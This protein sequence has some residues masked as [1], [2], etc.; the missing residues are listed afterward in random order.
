METER[1]IMIISDNEQCFDLQ[2]AVIV[3]CPL[4]RGVCGGSP[5]GGP[6]WVQIYLSSLWRTLRRTATCAVLQMPPLRICEYA[7]RVMAM[8]EGGW[9]LKEEKARKKWRK[10]E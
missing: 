6:P 1:V 8:K 9:K 5:S 10:K 4:V 3:T 7:R 2:R